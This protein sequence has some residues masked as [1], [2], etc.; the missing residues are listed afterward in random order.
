MITLCCQNTIMTQFTN[1][2]LISSSE[3]KP[4]TIKESPSGELVDELMQLL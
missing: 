3:R 4:N 2:Y 1:F